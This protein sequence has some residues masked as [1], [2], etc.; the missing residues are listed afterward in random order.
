M[1]AKGGGGTLKF[2]GHVDSSIRV[3]ELEESLRDKQHSITGGGTD[4]DLERP[5]LQWSFSELLVVAPPS[6]N[7]AAT[8]AS[9]AAKSP[10][11][12]TP[13]QTK[14]GGGQ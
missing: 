9:S 5:Q 11:A 12:K 7:A 6:D 1:M 13:A 3:A 8:A 4:Q 10:A 14:Q 2:N